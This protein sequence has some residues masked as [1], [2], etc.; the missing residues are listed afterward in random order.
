[1]D[2]GIVH[3][4]KPNYHYKLTI[5]LAIISFMPFSTKHA[6][7]GILLSAMLWILALLC[8]YLVHNMVQIIHGHI[9]FFH[10][11]FCFKKMK[12]TW[13]LRE[14]NM[15]LINSFILASNRDVVWSYS[16]RSSFCSSLINWITDKMENMHAKCHL[17]TKHHNSDSL[18][19]NEFDICKSDVNYGN[20]GK[21]YGIKRWSNV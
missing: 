16:Y 19:K 14:C 7:S 13:Y 12:H 6:T 15:V 11:P 1:M 17:S 9:N 2:N 10:W 4:P 5:W 18:C 3:L 8:S 21:N 20:Y